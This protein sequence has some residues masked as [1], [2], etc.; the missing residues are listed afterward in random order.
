MI[1]A[2]QWKSLTAKEKKAYAK[3]Q[4]VYAAFLDQ[5]DYE[6]G[7]PKLMGTHIC[8]DFILAKS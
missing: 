4:E 5:T 6:L 3:L 8:F 1:K 7:L 2:E